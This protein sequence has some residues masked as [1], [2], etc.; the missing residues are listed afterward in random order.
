MRPLLPSTSV[1]TEES[2]TLAVSSTFCSRLTVIGSFL[3]QRFAIAHQV[4]QFPHR[5]G[6]D[7]AGLEQP[8][9]QQVG[10]PL[11]ILDIGVG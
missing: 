9:P 6:W 3:H 4:A 5:F 8:M 11:T 7:K 2:L 10:Q 1:A